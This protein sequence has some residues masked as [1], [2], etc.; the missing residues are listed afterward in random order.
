MDVEPVW[1][2]GSVL[3]GQQACDELRAHGIKCDCI[4][5]QTPFVPGGMASNVPLQVVVAPEDAQRAQAILWAWYD[6]REKR[7]E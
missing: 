5:P 4:E 7:R 6:D 2:A 1:D 3:E